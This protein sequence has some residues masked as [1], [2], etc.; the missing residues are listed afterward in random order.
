MHW[1]VRFPSESMPKKTLKNT[2]GRNTTWSVFKAYVFFFFFCIGKLDDGFSCG[3]YTLQN[4]SN[5]TPLPIAA[6][7]QCDYYFYG[8]SFVMTESDL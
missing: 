4:S 1:D 7:L 3:H 8:M 5:T 2:T 6:V